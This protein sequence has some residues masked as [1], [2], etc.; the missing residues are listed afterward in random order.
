MVKDPL[1]ILIAGDS[2][3]AIWPAGDHGWPMLLNQNFNIVNV[4]QAG[5]S[6]YKILQQIKNH[7]NDLYDLVIIS[8]TSPSRIHVKEHPVYK[9][10]FHS[11]CDLIFEDIFS[12]SSFLNTEIQTAQNWF[13]LYYDDQYQIDIYNLLREKI[14]SMI[15]VPYIALSHVKISAELAIEKTHIDFSNLWAK[16]RGI[17]NHYTIDGNHIIYQQLLKEI[18]G[19]NR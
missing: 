10:G 16:E 9:T 12:K 14:N 4:A 19:F 5:V 18:N 2:F 6:E 1:K 11:N 3:A 15:S 8:H 13:R 17:T 7:Y